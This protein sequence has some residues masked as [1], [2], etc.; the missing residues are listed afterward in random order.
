MAAA[1]LSRLHAQQPAARAQRAQQQQSDPERRKRRLSAARCAVL[2]VQWRP[3]E[4]E[5]RRCAR[6]MLARARAG[7]LL[8]LAAVLMLGLALLWGAAQPRAAASLGVRRGGGGEEWAARL[9]GALGLAPLAQAAQDAGLHGL[10]ISVLLALA[11][12]VYR[13]CVAGVLDRLG[14]RFLA[15]ALRPAA[16]SS[17][18]MDE[19][20]VDD[21]KGMP[22]LVDL[23]SAGDAEDERAG[24]RRRRRGGS[25][26]GALG[27][28]SSPGMPG[29]E[30]SAA[31]AA[32]ATTT[33]PATSTAT[34][35]PPRGR[36]PLELQE[37][38]LIPCELAP[39]FS[40]PPGWLAFD[41]QLGMVPYA[42]KQAWDAAAAAAAAAAASADAA[43]AGAGPPE[44]RKLPPV[45]NSGAASPAREPQPAAASAGPKAQSA[46]AR[47]RA[48]KKAAA[49]QLAQEA[50]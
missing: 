36:G 2:G 3:G 16:A 48:R 10:L 30:S 8:T 7:A 9:L 20:K 37:S 15:Q 32:A 6:A 34:R 29:E 31:A 12:F 1:L 23:A 11:S 14:L 17:A 49:Q 19:P 4:V 46:Q 38:C 40:A 43:A 24:S 25:L 35:A 22:E 18:L 47:K 26:A 50:A 28:A 21:L 13:R 41:A 5:G 33:T 42:S 45:R 27:S 39:L 44:P